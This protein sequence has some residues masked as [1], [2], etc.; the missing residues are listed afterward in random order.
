MSLSS[1]QISDLPLPR[2]RSI[3]VASD[4]C[5]EMSVFYEIAGQG[6]GLVNV[7]LTAISSQY[8]RQLTLTEGELDKFF[9]TFMCVGRV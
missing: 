5:G 4:F 7:Q 1:Q 9:G 2:V 8:T 6:P 3:F